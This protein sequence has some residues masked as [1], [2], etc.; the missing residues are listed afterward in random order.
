MWQ[1]PLYTHFAKRPDYVE[2]AYLVTTVQS[3]PKRLQSG[4]MPCQL[5]YPHDS[6]DSEDLDDTTD[7]LE[8]FG[9]VTCAVKSQRQVER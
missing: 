2:Y 9:T 5:Q 3:V 4:G 1:K 7:V 6:H 8:L